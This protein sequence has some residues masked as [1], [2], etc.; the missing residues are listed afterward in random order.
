[1]K[2]LTSVYEISFSKFRV[3]V[4]NSLGWKDR[5]I[6]GGRVV[7]AEEKRKRNGG[8]DGDGARTGIW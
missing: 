6:G 5:F 8:G 4:Q 7:F 3:L 1:M 2:K